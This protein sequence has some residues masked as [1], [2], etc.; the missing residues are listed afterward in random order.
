M[1]NLRGLHVLSPFVTFRWS[2]VGQALV[3]YG[4]LTPAVLNRVPGA[5]MYLGL[6]LEGM[7]IVKAAPNHSNGAIYEGTHMERGIAVYS[8]LAHRHLGVPLR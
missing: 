3:R 2:G 5:M 1:Q 6:M 4:S 7:D 8:S